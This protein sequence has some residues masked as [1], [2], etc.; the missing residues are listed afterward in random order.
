MTDL[1]FSEACERNKQPIL[2][3][4]EQV[5]PKQGLVLEI[6]SCTGQHVV[7][8]ANALPLLN[9]QPSDRDEHLAGLTARIWQ[10]GGNNILDPLLLDVSATW[11]D[12]RF[13][14]A[15]SSNTAHI[16][17]WDAV[18]SMFEGVSAGLA[19]HGVFCLYGPFNE[20]GAYTAESNREFDRSLRLRDPGMGIRDL[21]ALEK[22]A[23][24]HQ[25]EFEEQFRLPANNSLLVFRKK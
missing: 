25:M 5:L 20:N 7:F 24:N 19:G 13:D 11:P 1:P 18:C 12:I 15:Y 21:E 16:M 9:W 2:E 6:G 8:F 23:R 14:A 17:N 3:V 10:Q 22:L 4:L